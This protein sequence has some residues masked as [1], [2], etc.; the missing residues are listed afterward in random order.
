MGR[1]TPC[2]N[3]HTSPETAGI[4]N[5]TQVNMKNMRLKKD[6]DGMNNKINTFMYKGVENKKQYKG[7]WTEEEFSQ[8]IFDFFKYCDDIELKPT[9]PLLRLW[10]SVTRHTINEWRKNP[11]QYGYKSSIIETAYDIMEAHLQERAEKYPTA[12]IFLLKT[13]HGHIE[14]SKV[15]VTSNGAEVTDQSNVLELVDKLGLAKPK[16]LGDGSDE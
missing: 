12:S 2:K 9:A 3:I 11:N 1:T 5:M 7:K 13:T 6:T 10:L 14:T 16:E 15:D 4:Q 8:T